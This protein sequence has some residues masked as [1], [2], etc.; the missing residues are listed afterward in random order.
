LDST[1][2]AGTFESDGPKVMASR[3]DNLGT[4]DGRLDTVAVIREMAAI[5]PSLSAVLAKDAAFL[6]D[7]PYLKISWIAKE[8]VAMAQRGELDPVRDVLALAERVYR[9]YG[10]EGRDFIGAG[11]LEGIPDGGEGLL[12]PLAGP[13]IAQEMRQF[14]DGR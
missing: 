13:L 1:R 8:L 5:A 4:E 7:E 14:V 9:D 10:Q 2:R 3:S 11:L 12:Q 6:A